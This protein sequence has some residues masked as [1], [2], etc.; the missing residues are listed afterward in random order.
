M[1]NRLRRIVFLPLGMAIRTLE[2]IVLNL[3]NDRLGRGA[4]RRLVR[5][6]A[7][8]AGSDLWILRGCKI[9]GF[10]LIDIGNHSGIG[11]GCIIDIGPGDGRF[12]VGSYT[13]LGPQC[14]VRNANHKFED[15]GIPIALQPHEVK[16]IVIGDNV[17]VGARTI[18]LGGARIGDNCVIAAG[19]V[20]SFEIPPN[21]LAAGNPARVIKKILKNDEPSRDALV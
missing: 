12:H 4:R 10:H 21:S 16:D 11:D 8:R 20:I 13:F 9:S 7:H 18:L 3:P 6:R 17:W 2:W 15:P 5:L 1:N 14:F 19:S